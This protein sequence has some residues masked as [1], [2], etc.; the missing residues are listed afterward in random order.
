MSNT[1]SYGRYEEAFKA[2]H[3]ALYD[4]MAPPP[5][6]RITKLEF[7]WNSGGTLATLKAY[8]SATLLFTISFSWNADGTL[9]EVTR[10][11]A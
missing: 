6:N 1:V 5:G 11:D 3:S 9:R 2:I 8:E 4:L 7:A 10:L